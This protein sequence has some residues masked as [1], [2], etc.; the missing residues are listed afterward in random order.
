[1]QSTESWLIWKTSYGDGEYAENLY[2]DENNLTNDKNNQSPT[3]PIP[4]SEVE[5]A[6]PKLPMELMTYQQTC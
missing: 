5:E 2:H 4:E 3:P 6:V 1:M